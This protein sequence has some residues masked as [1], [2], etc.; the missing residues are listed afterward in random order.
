M[1]R[2]RN[3]KPVELD[4]DAPGKDM[5]RLFTTSLGGGQPDASQATALP[6]ERLL[7]NPYQPRAA[8]NAEAL[9]E[10]ASVIRGQGFQGVLL[11]R[12]HPEQRGHYQLTAGHRRRD[13]SRLVGIASLPVIVRELSDEEMAM[14]AI[15]ENI[16]RED[17][18]PLEEGKIYVLMQEEMGYTLE[19][20]AK[21]V[22]KKLGYVY[23]RVRVAKAPPDIQALVEQ[24]PDSLRAVANLV[25]VESEQDRAMII[26]SLLRGAITTD[27]ILAYVKEIREERKAVAGAA[28]QATQEE[29]AP[30]VPTS[31]SE[32]EVGEGKGAAPVETVLVDGVEIPVERDR[33]TQTSSREEAKRDW[34]EVRFQQRARRSKLA[35]IAALLQ[36]YTDSIDSTTELSMEEKLDLATITIMVRRLAIML[37]LEREIENPGGDVP[38]AR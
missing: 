15:T 4:L 7:D 34:V 2:K 36:N 16:Q 6:I 10:L 20:I 13:A 30:P 29:S 21:E 31:L 38:G 23:N 3:L 27:D 17:L 35:R 24:K 8:V 18:T 33:P 28:E 12:P 9:E 32:P 37:G 14:L 11:A 25:R 19:Q 5:S 1:T 26:D 22:G